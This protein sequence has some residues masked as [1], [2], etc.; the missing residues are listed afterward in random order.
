MSLLQSEGIESYLADEH[1]AR[2]EPISSILAGGIRLLVRDG[3]APRA[4][5]V[6][7]RAEEGELDLPAWEGDPAGVPLVERVAAAGEVRCPRCGSAH[8]AKKSRM[9]AFLGAKYRCRVCGR[10]F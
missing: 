7:M 4:R 5:E 1:L 9:R 6:L 8:V 2:N 10:K 3:D